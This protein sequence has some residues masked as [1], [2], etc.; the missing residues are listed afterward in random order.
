MAVPG[1]AG[2]AGRRHAGLP[3][4]MSRLPYRS[5][6][7]RKPGVDHR[8]RVHFLHDRG[9][10][11]HAACGEPVAIVARAVHEAARL[12]EE[13]PGVRCEG[14]ADTSPPLPPPREGSS[15]SF[16]LTMLPTAVSRRVTNST[17]S[18]GAENP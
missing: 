10:L 14:A 7:A 18:P 12:G 16:G 13:D 9:A 5:V 8:R 3:A 15:R 11:D 2:G 6:S 4:L 1:P 17:G